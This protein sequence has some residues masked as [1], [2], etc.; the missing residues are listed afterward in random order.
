LPFQ[1]LVGA[2]GD[3]MV[4]TSDAVRCDLAKLTP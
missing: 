4:M 2:G 3:V 1:S